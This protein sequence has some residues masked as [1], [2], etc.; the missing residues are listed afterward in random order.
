MQE[1]EEGETDGFTEEDLDS[2][3]ENLR[4]HIRRSREGAPFADESEGSPSPETELRYLE[5]LKEWEEAPLTTW[6]Q[7]LWVKGYEF[8]EPATLDESSLS[9]ELQRLIDALAASNIY[10]EYTNHLSDRELYEHLLHKT[11]EEPVE[12]TVDTTPAAWHV[13]LTGAGSEKDLD[14]WLRYY[15]G[16]DERTYWQESFPDRVLPPKEIRP[17]DRDQH[18]PRP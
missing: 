12:Q 8:P 16:D 2:R 17:Y 18:L 5:Q 13:D 6:T 7:E 9:R 14:A 3:I 1:E 11:L 4:K 10:L 15:A